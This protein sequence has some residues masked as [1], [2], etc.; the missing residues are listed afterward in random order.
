MNEPTPRNIP[1]AFTWQEQNSYTSSLA[2]T[3]GTFQ[4][5]AGTAG[6][7]E[8]KLPREVQKGHWVLEGT[9]AGKRQLCG[10]SSYLGCSF[11]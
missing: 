3:E 10:P 7:R 5:S 11:V 2:T 8:D 1:C 4:E 9:A 6:R